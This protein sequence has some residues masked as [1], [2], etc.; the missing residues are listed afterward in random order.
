MSKQW[1]TVHPK[2]YVLATDIG[3]FD[4]LA[5]LALDMR[6]SWNH[7]SDQIWRQLDP[8]LWELTH[9]P[10]VVLQTVSRDKLEGELADPAFRQTIDELVQARQHAADAPALF[11]QAHPQSPLRCV[12]YFSME[13]MLSEALPIYS[14]GLGNVADAE[15]RTRGFVHLAEYHHHVSQH[16]RRAHVA[17]KLLAFA[18]TF[19]D[20]TKNTDAFVLSN[21]VIDHLGE[22]H[23]LA[24][25]GPAKQARFPAALQW[26]QH[27]NDLDARFED[28]RLG[29]TPR[30]RRRRPMHGSPLDIG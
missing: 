2:E 7:A 8:V 27:I 1:R 11:Q 24:H 6:S 22:Q 14:G 13:F 10:W 17:V 20:A 12:A 28:F 25:A 3:G 5:A 21:H 19:A 18:T 16:T 9:N 30:Q 23:R 29:G 4:S 26:H 15:T